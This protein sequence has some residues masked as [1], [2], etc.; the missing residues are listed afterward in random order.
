MADASIALNRFGYGARPGDPVP[1]DPQRWL[2]AQFDRYDARPA[3]IAALPGHAKVAA[4]LVDYYAMRAALPKTA[5]APKRPRPAVASPAADETT[6]MAAAPADMT[7]TAMTPGTMPPRHAKPDPATMSPAD[8][9]VFAQRQQLQDASHQ[10][11]R[12]NY[13]AAV[14]AR[15]EATLTS[16]SPFIERMVHFWA[17]HF[18]VSADKLELIGLSGTLEMEA[19]RPN[20]LGTFGQMLNAVEHHPAML[21]YLDQAVSI[22]P[23]SAVGA[24]ARR[25]VGLNENLG[26]EIMELHTLGVRT[27]YSQADV[28]EFAR[29]LTGWTVSGI[30]RGPSLRL[31]ANA[32]PGAFMFIDAMHEPGTRT[33]MGKSYPQAGEAQAQAI[34]NDLAASPAT[35]AHIATKIAR[36]FAGDTPPPALVARLQT[37][38][39]QSHG[40]LPTLYRTLIDSPEA[41]A[42]SA[43]KFKSPWDWT[44]SAYRAVGA[45]EVRPAVVT[46]LLNKLGQPIWKPGSPAGYEDLSAT[47]AGPDAVMRRVEAATQFGAQAGNTIDARALAPKLFPAALTPS[48]GEALTRAESPNQALALLLV[49]PEFMRR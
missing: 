7:A 23:N 49:S 39:L 34:L 37:A 33:I 10:I 3:L 16:D 22:G 24:R 35:A 43:Q 11:G 30:A 47:W 42:P 6:S 9:A 27:G 45:K 44:V 14:A 29:A 17:N 21:V 8:R 1:D 41:W 19:I 13:I 48:T 2:I 15:T 31:T 40:D 46:A 38:F 5:R 12:D 36:H 28:T 20:V 4:E 18:A 26:R 25:N 32:E